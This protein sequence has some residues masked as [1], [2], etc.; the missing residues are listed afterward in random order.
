MNI[1]KL[2][3]EVQDMQQIELDC[4]ED[5]MLM[6]W[7]EEPTYKL[8]PNTE[9]YTLCPAYMVHADMGE[10]ME[11]EVSDCVDEAIEELL[12]EMITGMMLRSIASPF[13]TG[14]KLPRSW[15]ILLTVP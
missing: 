1:S 13:E 9:R 12:T 14:R 7:Y 4:L 10:M 15:G 2:Q 3:Q 5:D 6:K 11:A 8:D